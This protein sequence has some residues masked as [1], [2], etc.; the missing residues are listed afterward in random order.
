[1]AIRSGIPIFGS[2]TLLLGGDGA[3]GDGAASDKVFF[4]QL[5]V[6]PGALLPKA[7]LLRPKKPMNEE[8]D[9]TRRAS[10][11]TACSGSRMSRIN[12]V[13]RRELL[14]SVPA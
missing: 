9:V 11:R 5:K 14:R 13:D 4:E 1:V 2:T 3:L 6:E 7:G 8:K 12:R 10:R